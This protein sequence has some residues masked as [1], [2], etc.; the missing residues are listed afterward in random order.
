MSRRIAIIGGGPRALWALE[1]LI[2]QAQERSSHRAPGPLQIDVWEPHTPGAGRV[3]RWDQPGYFRLNV[4]A[5]A[6][7]TGMGPLTQWLSS[8]E[9]FPPR[10][11]VGRYLAESWQHAL[12][13]LPD[14]WRVRHLRA[15]ASDV[16]CEGGSD[17][18][19][20]GD[21]DGDR[22]GDRDG[23][24][25]VAGVLC[26]P[27]TTE[28]EA[29][30]QCRPSL[31]QAGGE[32]RE[33]YDDVLISIGHG[34][35]WPGA[36]RPG[37]SGVPVYSVYERAGVPTLDSIAPGATVGVR[38]AALTFVD[39]CLALSIGRGG[40]FHRA[41]DGHLRYRP[42]GREPAKI[43]PAS[44]SGRLME[45]KLD[46]ESPLMGLQPPG[47]P[48]CAE[49][50]RSAAGMQDVLDAV[51]DAAELFLT[52]AS[53]LP[54]LRERTPGAVGPAERTQIR[55]VL[56]GTDH[57]L[58]GT[59]ADPIEAFRHSLAVAQGEAAP[60]AAWAVGE[61]WR[62]L[63][64]AIVERASHGGRATL[65]GFAQLDRTLE[66][67][68]FGPPP[69]T[70]EA[71]IALVDAGLVSGDALGDAS[72]IQRWLGAEPPEQ[73]CVD[74]VVD[75]VLAPTGA[76]P[77]TLTARLRERGVLPTAPDGR[78]ILTHRDASVP[79]CPALAVVGR[80][81]EGTVWGPDTLIRTVHGEIPAW[82]GRVLD[83]S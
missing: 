26:E 43:I 2:R 31:P 10:R 32:L 36:L 41:E 15:W 27:A 14:G 64:A 46:P 48:A 80:D 51:A 62:Q 69:Q 75:A 61:A 44:R 74:A 83:R 30:G 76:V 45:V 37:A 29:E 73:P 1:E 9:H 78:S 63:Y 59:T 34:D 47:F 42:S 12:G 22:D 3:Y 6:V 67:V 4:R 66:R 55:R 77:G 18:G 39:A 82:A 28:G 65:P 25:L 52:Q 23:S 71:V 17:G 40:E 60:T 20:D 53:A 57:L 56:D 19:R 50:V 11:D 68:A 13:Q 7:A 5:G 35:T 33:T 38:G 72:A 24:V 58:G 21:H 49:R 8:P 54:Q 16:I 79:G 81:T 70:A